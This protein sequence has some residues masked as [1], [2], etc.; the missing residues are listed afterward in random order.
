M[1]LYMESM[2][3]LMCGRFFYIAQSFADARETW[4]AEFSQTPQSNFN[5]APGQQL[6]VILNEDDS[7]IIAARWGLI[8]SWAKDAKIGY[9][10]INARAETIS[11]KPMFK[12]AF[13]QR[14]CLVL[15]SDFYEWKKAE[16]K[17]PYA[18]KLMDRDYFAFA[19]LWDV[20]K[21]EKG[22]ALTSF[23]IITTSPNAIMKKIHDRM[24][25]ILPREKERVWLQKPVVELLAPYDAKKMEAYEVS[26]LVNSPRNNRLEVCMP[27]EH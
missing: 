3:I 17:I 5:A 21:D 1:F 27:V 13:E 20:W 12:K 4:N 16:E 8:P 26:T 6:P 19:G 7:K 15:A 2:S 11:E 25:V 14:R 10:L 23:T 9:K 24:P 18:V 22:N